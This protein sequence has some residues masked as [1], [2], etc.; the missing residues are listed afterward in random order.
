MTLYE[1]KSLLAAHPDRVFRLRLPDGDA[2]PVSF[3]ITEV[4]CVHKTFLDCG[5]TLRELTTMNLFE[6]QLTLWVGLCIVAGIASA[7]SPRTSPRPSTG[8]R[9]T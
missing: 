8:W 2:V 5:G 6:R 4:G 9:S 3:H 7:K 1:L